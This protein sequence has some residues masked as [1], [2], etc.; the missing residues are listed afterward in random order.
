[1]PNKL[2]SFFQ[3]VARA[4]LIPASLVAAASLIMAVGSLFTD[5]SIVAIVPIFDNK[6]V[7]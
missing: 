3:K 5:P 4:F 6:L 7:L 1:M 2:K